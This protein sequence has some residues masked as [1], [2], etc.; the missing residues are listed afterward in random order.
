MALATEVQRRLLPQSAPSVPGTSLDAFTL[1]ARTVGG[2]YYD[3]LQLGDRQ[4]GIALSDIAGKG[5]PAA[6]IMGVV[7][8]SLRMLASENNLSLP[9][10]AAKMN[11]FLHR[12]TGSASYAT[13]FYALL[14]S[15]SRRL[16][17]VNAGHNPPYVVR[18]RDHAA[19]PHEA[20]IEE[21]SDGGTVIGLFPVAAYE[22][23]AVDLNPGDLV[24]AF[25]DGVPEALNFAEEE[26]GEERLK[27]LIRNSADLPIREI[28]A[29]LSDALRAWIGDAPQ[30]DD[31][32][33]VVLKV[34]EP[35]AGPPTATGE[36]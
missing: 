30:Y 22:Q 17:Y 27:E 33:F 6:L 18:R 35:S 21:L 26:F 28:T 29:A 13:F 12:S 32:T 25:T 23:A 2:D 34:D 3:F 5:I 36:P 14:D 16:C 4:V 20:K 19:A 7:Q 11:R 1:P 9:E 10:L 15:D 24:I 31:I 8:A